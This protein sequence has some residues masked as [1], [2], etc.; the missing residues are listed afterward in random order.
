MMHGYGQFLWPNGES[1]YIG[2]FK[3]DKRHGYGEYIYDYGMRSYRGN[4][5]K[6]LQ[7]GTGYVKV[8]LKVKEQKGLWKQG[9]LI[10]WYQ[11]SDSEISESGTDKYKSVRT[12]EK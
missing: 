12:S 4:W 11:N 9:E 5:K 3:C 10:K 1:K 8:S 2:A 7:H 6:D